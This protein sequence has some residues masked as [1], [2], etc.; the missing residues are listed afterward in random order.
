MHKEKQSSRSKKISSLQMKRPSA[1]CKNHRTLRLIS[2]VNL[3]RS[4]YLF[5]DYRVFTLSPFNS[6]L[7]K[8]N[9]LDTV[10]WPSVTSFFRTAACMQFYIRR[11]MHPAEF[12]SNSPAIVLFNQLHALD[13]KSYERGECQLDTLLRISA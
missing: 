10:S 4:I 8:E 3:V 13:P 12:F 7:E 5:L 9:I 2:R 1:E 11:G 6:L